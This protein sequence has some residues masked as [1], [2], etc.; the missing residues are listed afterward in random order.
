MQKAKIREFFD[1]FLLEKQHE[2]LGFLSSIP[3]RTH[4]EGE[5]WTMKRAD[6]SSDSSEYNTLETV[7]SIDINDVPTLTLDKV[8]QKLDDAA[9]EMAKQMSQGIYKSINELTQKYDQVIDSKGKGLTKETFLETFE[10]VT[11]SFD[12]QG[13]PIFPSLIMHPNTWER[14]REDAASWDDDPDFKTRHAAILES[15]RI[16]WSD[17]ESRRKLVD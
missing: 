13:N 7:F 6:G 3:S 17:R 9:R 5:R 12:K 8:M 11:I 16:E 1:R 14:V 10:R 4:H 15:K 2:Y